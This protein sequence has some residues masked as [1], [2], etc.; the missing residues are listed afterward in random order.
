MQEAG[1]NIAD[2][3]ASYADLE[4]VIQGSICP[5]E[6]NSSDESEYYDDVF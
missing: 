2:F 5:S 3:S 6:E 4:N 1:Q